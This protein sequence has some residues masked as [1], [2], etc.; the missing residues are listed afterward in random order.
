[1]KNNDKII[2]I[3][4]LLYSLCLNTFSQDL[5]SLPQQQRDSILIEVAKEVVLKYGPG[6]YREYKRPIITRRQILPM[7]DINVTGK[8][9]GRIFYEVIFLYDETKELLEYD[10]AARVAIWGDTHKPIRV[11]FGNGFIKKIPEVD[12]RSSKTV[13][14]VPYQQTAEWMREYVKAL[15]NKDKD[16]E[17]AD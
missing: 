3:I 15:R 10:F 11:L 6:Y 9:A 5:D 7:G 8:N 12:L 2:Y 1:M 14:Q 13:D 16:G 4:I 17:K